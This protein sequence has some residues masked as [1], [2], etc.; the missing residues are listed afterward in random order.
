MRTVV[1]LSYHYP[2]LGGVAV[3]RALRFTRYLPEHGWKP[4]VV[5]VQGG[6]RE[7]RDPQL[8]EEVPP[9]AEVHRVACLEPDNYSDSWEHPRQK[10]VRNLFKT[11]DFVL[12]PDDRALWI[13]PA[14]RKAVELVRK[15]RADALWA[16]AQ[17]FS[18]LVA[19]LRVHR[20]TG[21]PLVVDFRDDWTTS[22]ADFRRHSP[23]RQKREIA[24]EA[25]ILSAASAVVTVTPGIVDALRARKPPGTS[26]DKFHLLPNGFDP[27]HF[28]PRNG[29][30]Q[31]TDFRILH[32]GGM[33][34]RRDPRVF[35]EGLRRFLDAH[36]EARA[37]TRVR[38]AGR[39]DDRS[40]PL[41]EAG[42]LR[43]VVECP[44][45]LPHRRVREELQASDVLLLL[46]EQVKTVHWLYSGKIFEYIAA[47][48]PILAPNPPDSPISEIIR[49]TGIGEVVAPDS[50]GEVAAAL[51]R[52]Y[53]RRNQ[54]I[55]A[56]PAV[57]ARYDARSQTG[58]LA[59]ILESCCG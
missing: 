17:P 26:D 52:L 18:T 3:M 10:I 20:R 2:P 22:N 49:E 43:G 46:L 44:G 41:L 27:A 53:E 58:E 24:L 55:E 54:P 38:F 25:E 4:V 19:G 29:A 32:A 6:G 9:E 48:R 14:A 16:T 23:G 12:F 50:P 15:Y 51:S 8:L 33:Y 47:R 59:R 37:H 28:P 30:R 31:G 5:A 40:R 45:F 42:D 13:G 11:F 7:P 56:A 35:L 1:M 57:V 34:P 39:V 21:V 36:P